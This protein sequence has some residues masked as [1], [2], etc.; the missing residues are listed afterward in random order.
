[1]WK[2]AANY[3]KASVPAIKTPITEKKHK[4]TFYLGLWKMPLPTLKREQDNAA[5]TCWTTLSLSPG[6]KEKE[7]FKQQPCHVLLL[8]LVYGFAYLKHNFFSCLFWW[9][10]HLDFF[11]VLRL[12]SNTPKLTSQ[13][14]PCTADWSYRAVA[15][16]WKFKWQKNHL[17]CLCSTNG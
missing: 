15:D 14:F 4:Y 11:L 10:A 1:M 8:S 3:I 13:H 7:K 9:K 5:Y 16:T 6:F 12:W 2:P 17:P